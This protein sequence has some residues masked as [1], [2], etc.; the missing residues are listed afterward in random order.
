MKERKGPSLRVTVLIYCQL[1]MTLTNLSPASR[2]GV[3][4][5]DALK[6][7]LDLG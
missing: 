7:P 5:S 6:W 4:E 1:H 2:L 3:T